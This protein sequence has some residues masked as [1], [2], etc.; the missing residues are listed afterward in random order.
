MWVKKVPSTGRVRYCE[1]YTDYLTGK[2]KDVSVTFEK[3]NARN[4]KE[5]QLLLAKLI[6]EK[7]HPQSAPLTLSQLIDEY[8]KSQKNKVRPS[9]YMRNVFALNSVAKILGG[10]VLVDRM[11][12]RYIEDS[13]L[14]TGRE[15]D[16][17]N[18]FMKRF[19]ALIRWGYRSD[20]ISSTDFLN[21]LQPFKGISHKTKIAEK[22]MEVSELNM[23]LDNMDIEVWKLFT[24]FLALSGLRCGEAIALEKSDIDMTNKVIHITKSY[25]SQLDVVCP[26]KTDNSVDDVVIQPQLEAVIKRI[27]NVMKVQQVKYAYRTKLFFSDLQGEHLHYFAYN[28]YLKAVTLETIGRALTP[29]SLRHTH[30]SLLFEQGFTVDEVARRLRHGD[31][32]VTRE[33]YIHVTKKLKEKD[34][35]KLKSAILM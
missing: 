33:V 14:A 31:S 28:K 5:A 29:H 12:A 18:E 7:Q 2:H 1:R 17:L 8:N 20:L 19:K 15:A 34:A 3:D 9:T 4:R 6:E 13:F 23:V 22:Y 35:E 26:A 25:N 21:K 30:A 11:T 27:Q 32:K 10:D 16:T 24:E